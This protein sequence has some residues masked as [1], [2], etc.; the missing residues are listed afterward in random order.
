MGSL[1]SKEKNDFNIETLKNHTVLS[2]LNKKNI[3]APTIILELYHWIKNNVLSTDIYKN[4]L[5]IA[6]LARN[7]EK[8]KA[9]LIEILG[10][11][12]FNITDIDVV[13]TKVDDN[14]IEEIQ[15]ND[16][17]SEAIKVKLL[18]TRKQVFFTHKSNDSTFQISLGMES[19]GTK[20]YFRLTRLLLK[21][22]SGN[23]IILEDELEDSLHYDLLLHF[24]ETYIRIENNNQLIFTTHNQMLLDESWLVRRDMI[25]LIEKSQKS[26]F[27]QIYKVS[28]LGLHKNI[29]ILNAYRIGKLGGKPN[30][31]TTFLND[32]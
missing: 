13:E 1:L 31:G 18:Q 14:L 28:D 22:K 19:S 2:T 5:E 6:E 25:C 26:S 21:L 11:A 10:K 4:T 20:A 9:F 8:I 7:D 27:S 17:I 16:T 12:D 29:S 24:L 32:N 15:K 30:L 23:T 3:K